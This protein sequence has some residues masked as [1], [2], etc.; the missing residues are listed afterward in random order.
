MTPSAE[1]LADQLKELRDIAG[2][3]VP[4]IHFHGGKSTAKDVDAYQH[5]GVDHVLVDLPTE[6]RDETLRRLDEFQTE[7]AQLG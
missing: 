3:D 1:A 4:V 7:F 5:L 2:P 6:P